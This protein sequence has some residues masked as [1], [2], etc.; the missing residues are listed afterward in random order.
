MT[1]I[2]SLIDE[3]EIYL[4]RFD[5]EQVAAVRDGIAIWRRAERK[6][7]APHWE[8]ACLHL[9]AALRAVDVQSLA[10]A[11]N[12][13]APLLQWATYD[14]FSRENIGE[15]YADGHAF[16]AL[17]GEDAPVKSVD[18][19]LG[20]FVMAPR[21]LY[22]DHHHAAPELYAP[23]TGPHGWRFGPGDPFE[24]RPAHVPVW[25]EP[26][27]PH[28]TLVGDVPFLCIYCW[29]KDVNVPARIVAAPDWGDYE[30]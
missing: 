7:P 19:E 22:R 26:F 6:N 4:Q 5:G 1:L 15:K 23:L 20:L 28:A 13:G 29:T 27:A 21:V 14:A 25:N 9:E 8:P 18:F 24:P 16:A 3:I 2:T 17:I 30:T 10:K 12:A 11:L